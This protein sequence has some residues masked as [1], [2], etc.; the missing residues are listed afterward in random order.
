MTAGRKGNDGVDLAARIDALSP[1]RLALLTGA[2]IVVIAILLVFELNDKNAARELETELRLHQAVSDGADAANI[3]I[4]TGA[5]LRE[6]LAASLPGGQSALIHMSSSGDVLT[7]VGKS[8]VTEISIPVIQGLDLS[9]RGAQR[10]NQNVGDITA[11]WRVLDNGEVLMATAPARDIYARSNVWVIYAVI[12]A[13]M[14]V[15]VVSLMAAFI[16][17]SEA[18]AEAAHALAKLND[19]EAALSGGR[20]SPW[21]Y[22]QK[23]RGVLL[24]RSFLEPLGL[25]ARDRQFTLREITALVH[26]HDLRTALAIL[27]GEPSGVNEGVV[28]FRTPDGAW[29]R[30]YLRTSADATRFE[31]SGIAIDLAGARSIA[32]GAAIAE[33]RLRDAIEAIPEAFVLWDAKGRLAIWNRR[34]SSVFRIPSKV[35]RPGLTVSEVATCAGVAGDVIAS[36]FGPLEDKE[37]DT[38]EVALPGARWAHVSRRRTAEGG[39]VSVATNVTDMKRRA[40]AQKKKERELEQIVDDLQSSRLELSETNRKYQFE[41]YRAE[42]ASRSK[43]E[44]LANMSHELRTPLNAINGFSEVMQSE[45]YG[46]LGDEKYKD[47]V[48]DIISSGRHLLELIDDILDM[49]KIEAGKL[50][51]ESERVELE[52]VLNESIRLVSKRASDNGIKLNASVGHAPAIWGDPRAVKQVTLNLLSNAIKFTPNGGEI[53]LTAEADLDGVTI[54]VADSGAGIERAHL[55]KLGA[56]FEL[57][58]NHFA[59]SRDGSGLGLALSKSLVEM[60]GGILALASQP[61][62][63]T[64]ACATFPRRKDAKVRLPQFVRKEA[65]ILTGEETIAPSFDASRAA[66]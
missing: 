1:R 45:L 40:R 26:K 53:A 46:P 10:I 37:Q 54:I 36:S 8:A 24:S 16:R 65:H 25:G 31:R 43:S 63:G 19:F 50:Q 44:F 15:V 20:A 39:F 23:E 17:Q 28:R 55:K 27:S 13:A 6:S 48:S 49:S 64:V 11:V 33:T 14:T 47:Y 22:K 32:P 57:A 2:F 12:L 21:F 3:A 42:E 51:L 35:L 58:E 56:P 7:A 60:Q 66:E 34:F 4:M 29:S 52:K 5:P 41:K 59:K 38:A 9:T 30:T 62:K 61:G 18:A